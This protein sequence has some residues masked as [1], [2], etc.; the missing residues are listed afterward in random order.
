MQNTLCTTAALCV[1]LLALNPFAQ[2]ECSPCGVQSDVV[3]IEALLIQSTG[4]LFLNTHIYLGTYTIFTLS[5]TCF[6]CLMPSMN[7]LVSFSYI[8]G[9]P[10][11]KHKSFLK[12]Q[13]E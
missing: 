13:G 5:T 2:D 9:I 11:N 1:A 10:S 8:F 4:F 3:G 12:T 6:S 7:N